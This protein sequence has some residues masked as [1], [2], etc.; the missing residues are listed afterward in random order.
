MQNISFIGLGAMGTP[1]ALN[2]LKKKY[3][4]FIYDINNKNYKK[5][6]K[7]KAKICN[8]YKDLSSKSDVFISM[9]PDSKALSN[10]V[11]GKNGIINFIKKDSTFIDCSSVDYETT[12][13]ISDAFTKKSIKFIDAPVSGGV[14]GAEQATLTIM[15]GGKKKHIMKQKKY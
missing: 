8:N 5:F 10:L 6:Y 14:S 7:S 3:N 15:V 2:L 4:L 12:L 11:L 9:L 1:M 13:K